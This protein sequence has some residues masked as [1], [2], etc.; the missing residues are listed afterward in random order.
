M[1][2]RVYA[3]LALSIATTAG[4]C[5][6]TGNQEQEVAGEAKAAEPVNPP[7]SLTDKPAITRLFERWILAKETKAAAPVEVVGEVE[8]KQLNASR[9]YRCFANYN[10]NDQFNGTLDARVEVKNGK[11][12]A[13]R[14]RKFDGNM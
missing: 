4:G 6:D 11:I 5:A 7:V 2:Y 12:V 10:T 1:S 13:V 14:S 8:C 3:A 9:V